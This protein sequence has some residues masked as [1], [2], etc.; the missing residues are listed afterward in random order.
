MSYFVMGFVIGFF[1][2]GLIVCPLGDREERKRIYR[3]WKGY[4]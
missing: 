4:R 1:L 2:I 3:K